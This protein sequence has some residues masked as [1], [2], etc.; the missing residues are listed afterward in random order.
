MMDFCELYS[1]VECNP[2]QGTAVCQQKLPEWRKQATAVP[3]MDLKN[4]YLQVDVS[5]DLQHSQTIKY[6]GRLYDMTRIGLNFAPKIMPG[7]ISAALSKDVDVER[8]T[9][10]YTDGSIKVWYRKRRSDKFC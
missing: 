8:G 2:G 5:R 3:K 1:H 10:H 6:K 9:D 4:A 7:L